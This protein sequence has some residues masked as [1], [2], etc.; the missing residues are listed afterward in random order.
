MRFIEI[1]PNGESSSHPFVSVTVAK[2][3]KCDA[4]SLLKRLSHA[5]PLQL[6][7][8]EHLKR[9]RSA[10]LET[11]ESVLEVILHPAADLCDIPSDIS[12]LM[13]EKRD[14]CVSSCPPCTRGDF[15]EWGKL[16]PINYK[17]SEADRSRES[18]LPPEEYAQMEASIF[19]LRTEDETMFSLTGLA[20]YG[21][22]IVN[23]MN[24]KV[25]ATASAS[26]Q[27]RLSKMDRSLVLNHPLMSP[28]LLC[29]AAVSDALQNRPPDLMAHLPQDQYLCTRLDLYLSF[30]PELMSSMALVH[31]RIRRVV[32]IDSNTSSG[33]LGS[34]FNLIS[35]KSINHH[36]SV[37]KCVADDSAA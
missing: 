37:Y 13:L 9:I 25:I 5:L 27:N 19:Q 1:I 7:N 28:T 20:K 21:A 26:L 4:S 22:I 2:I 30:E 12:A 8:L 3:N 18:G 17:P 33:C 24:N 16:W 10:V 32:Y 11:G 6:F 14:I 23:P 34:R 35:V 36:Y 31:S 15:I 29:I